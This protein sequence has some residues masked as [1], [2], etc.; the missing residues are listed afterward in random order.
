MR[1]TTCTARLI[2]FVDLRPVHRIC[3]PRWR[4]KLQE[5]VKR[6]QWIL[7]PEVAAFEREFA[8]ATGAPFC[9]ATASGTDALTLALWLAGVS[10]PEQEVVTTPLSAPFTALAIVRAGARVRFADVDENTLLL[11]PA[12]AE[13]YLT[14]NTVAVLPVHLYGQ[15]CD[16][17]GWKRLAS[18]RQLALIQDACQAHGAFYC[19]RALT[20]FSHWVAYSFYPTKNLGALGDGGALCLAREGDLEMARALRDGGRR[21]DH[22]A[23]V[24]GM[25]SRLDELQ[26]AYL[27]VA[28]EHLPRWNERRRHLASIYDEELASIPVELIR[29]VK[30]FPE[31]AS[32]YHLYVVRANQ[33]EAL[34]EYLANHGVRTAIHYPV[35]L[36]LQP[37]F[38]SAG[39]RPGDLPVAEKATQEILSLPLGLHLRESD[40]RHVAALIRRF[41]L[42]P[43]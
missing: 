15:L 13:P 32:V 25:N 41:Y 22:V 12:T 30:R 34:R 38:A 20:E 28:L 6:S 42:G 31:R 8:D 11:E 35:P 2:D 23:V 26:A 3:L 16:L 33:R 24:P 27:R 37:A 1:S 7:G 39:L 10:T 18:N 14:R 19:G 9:V 29:P 40:V 36:H 17:P 43:R 4:R 5:L 21:E